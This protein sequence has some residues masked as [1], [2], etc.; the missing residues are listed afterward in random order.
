MLMV[1]MFLK[2]TLRSK[3]VKKKMMFMKNSKIFEMI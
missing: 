3:L 1:Q 2:K